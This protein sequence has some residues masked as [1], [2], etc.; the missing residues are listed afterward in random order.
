MDNVKALGKI[1]LNNGFQFDTWQVLP[2]RNLLIGHS[3]EVTIE[4]KMMDVLVFLVSHCG[5]MVEREKLISSVW[6][7]LVVTDD[8]LS[9]IISLLR[10]SL[11]DSSKKPIYIQTVPKK[12]YR[13]IA[14]IS[15]LPTHNKRYELARNWFA[16]KSF[17]FSIIA[18]FIVIGTLFIWKKTVI[19]EQAVKDTSSNVSKLINITDIEIAPT[20]LSIAILPFQREAGDVYQQFISEGLTDK[21][22]N[23]L[24]K[25]PGVKVVSR[26]KSQL[27]GRNKSSIIDFVLDGTIRQDPNKLVFSIQLIS[28]KGNDVIWS[29]VYE[30]D[31]ENQYDIQN[32]VIN[33]ITNAIQVELG[34]SSIKLIADIEIPPHPDAYQ[35]F[36]RGRQQFKLRGERAVR[37]SIRLF[38]ESILL[39]PNFQPTYISL[40]EAYSVLPF[41]STMPS[42]NGY[43]L[44]LNLLDNIKSNDKSIIADVLAIKAQ[45]ATRNWEWSKAE[46]LFKQSF[47]MSVH[48][49][50]TFLWYS[51]FLSAVG[52]LEDSSKAAMYSKELDGISA[53]V[54]NRLAVTYLWLNDN[55]QAEKYF[56]HGY[57]YGFINYTNPGYSIF[58]LRQHRI[59]QAKEALSL[60]LNAYGVSFD[61]IGPVLDGIYDNTKRLLAIRSLQSAIDKNQVPPRFQPG[62]W[63]YL[64]HYEKAYL[65]FESLLQNKYELDIEFLFSDEAKGFRKSAQFKNLTKTLGLQKYWLATGLPYYN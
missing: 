32:S 25:I 27:N 61:W 14:E 58:L 48:N 6:A 24:P 51:E 13:F 60:I 57:E 20:K 3:G 46:E 65:A 50:N 18:L 53:V 8:V 5:E 29:T 15:E 59:A 37:E 34:K 22:I 12:G 52:R 2:K 43:Q 63:I 39:D 49:A 19:D 17:Y 7:D 40:A 47:E 35:L 38:Q 10:T 31:L 45:I 9:R 4:P 16:T 42:R 54:N 33:L 11:G 64:E 21:L 56:T 36:V 28:V 30:S 62:L 1:D 26:G 41:Y 55:M 23:V 44:A